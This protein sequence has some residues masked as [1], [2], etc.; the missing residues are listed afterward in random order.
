MANAINYISS[1]IGS[2]GNLSIPVE[3]NFIVQFL[4]PIPDS[5][6]DLT[7]VD[8]IEPTKWEDTK[9]KS[10]QASTFATSNQDEYGILFASKIN[11][12][13]ESLTNQKVGIKETTTGILLG[14]PVLNNRA[15]NTNLKIDFIET[16]NSFPDFVIRPWV[17]AASHYGLFAR[18]KN[19]KQNV[20]REL[21]ITWLDYNKTPRK[22]FNFFDCVPVSLAG[23]E[24]SYS[25]SSQVRTISTD[26]IYKNYSLNS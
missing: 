12:P 1:E 25:D 14:A 21:K 13:G 15:Q 2:F 9:N 11:I 22:I 23:S 20:K 24:Y 26:W 3:A 7:G 8:S 19:S 5:I 16:N 18:D 10:S 17:L 4:N 6:Q